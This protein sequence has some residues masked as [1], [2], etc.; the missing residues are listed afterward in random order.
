MIQAADHRGLP[1]DRILPRGGVRRRMDDPSCRV[2]ERTIAFADPSGTACD[3]RA[4]R[5]EANMTRRDMAIQAT[6][7]LG[8]VCGIV[9]GN[10]LLHRWVVGDATSREAGAGTSSTRLE[11]D[12]LDEFAPPSRATIKA[13]VPSD[14]AVHRELLRK[15]IAEK[16]PQESAEVR[17]AWLEELGDVSRKAAEG[18]LDLRNQVGAFPEI[19]ESASPRSSPAQ[20]PKFNF[21]IGI[22]R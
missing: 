17:E 18:I 21:S 2:S 16:L 13:A 9:G 6:L 14:P 22:S 15:L 12:D 1:G 3:A 11:R 20:P 8:L 10:F 7:V 4:I 19:D 5:K